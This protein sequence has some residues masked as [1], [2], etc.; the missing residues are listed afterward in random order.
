[1]LQGRGSDVWFRWVSGFDSHVRCLTT[2]NH[3]WTN[4]LSTHQR[5]IV[6]I[7]V[8]VDDDDDGFSLL[9]LLISSSTP[10]LTQARRQPRKKT[11]LWPNP[12]QLNSTPLNPNQYSIPAISGPIP[13]INHPP[14][15]PGLDRS[16]Q[17]S[18]C[19]LR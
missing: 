13:I 8:I 17:S 6:G 10:F 12:A 9:S 15:Q 16:N 19:G 5:D 18:L 7:V 3:T 11:R 2:T 1:L 14:R 4:L